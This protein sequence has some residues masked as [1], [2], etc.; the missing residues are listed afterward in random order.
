MRHT[1]RWFPLAA[2]AIAVGCSDSPTQ[3]GGG[4][5]NPALTITPSSCQERSSLDPTFLDYHFMF[6]CGAK[7]WLD[8]TNG[9]LTASQQNDVVGAVSDWNSAL[10]QG[11]TGLPQFF[12]NHQV[13]DTRITITVSTQSATN[14]YE[15]ANNPSG[16]PVTQNINLAASGATNAAPFLNILHVEL[17]HVL[18]FGDQWESKFATAGVSD[19]CVRYSQN[20]PNNSTPCEHEIE[21]LFYT[22]G[23]RPGRSLL[24]HHI[25]TGFGGLPWAL[26]VSPGGGQPVAVHS[27]EF[28]RV[29]PAF[30]AGVLQAPRPRPAGAS[31]PGLPSCPD[32]SSIG[33]TW[34]SDNSSIASVSGS[35]PVA[36]ITGGGTV[37]TTVV[38]AAPVVNGAYDLAFF[39]TGDSI[40]VTNAP[41]APTSIVL[42][43]GAN[44]TAP[45]GTTLPVQPAVRVTGSG[46]AVVPGATVDFAVVSGGGSV[47]PASVVTDGSGQAS[48]SW[49]LGSV[50]GRQIISAT[51]H[52]TGLAVRDTATATGAPA[53]NLAIYAG[54]D[55]T[56]PA[57]TRLPI[58]PTVKVTDANGNGV[59]GVT[60]QFSAAFLNGT[61]SPT[62]AVTS[63]GG[64][65]STA[66]TLGLKATTKTM[67][68][69]STGLSGSPAT[70]TATATVGDGNFVVQSCRVVPAGPKNYNY[71]TLAWTGASSG[72]HTI[73]ESTSSD[74]ATATAIAG[75]SGSSGSVEV[76]GYLQ[77]APAN[78]RYW[79]LDDV[80]PVAG[81]PINTATCLN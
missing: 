35:G 50:T 4:L 77:Q 79:W 29:N 46:G 31:R 1:S 27:L 75:G 81:N 23:L 15:G 36:T 32:S 47:A 10:S 55:Q 5:G 22:Y 66:W 43:A 59:D 24:D 13:G 26:E 65:A 67:T 18:G 63:G 68:A 40:V 33:Y 56:A 11:V 49:H 58:N 17:T 38:R 45:A 37:G 30:C 20:A 25:L 2:L 57:G 8:T 76:G 70:F 61:V 71:F 16:A 54:N 12:L 69:T 51:V 9:G 62:S 41:P 21:D 28:R 60:V 48:T 14:Q 78:Y 34:S 52:G 74:P 3:P 42:T 80:T 7:I 39:F 44:Q 53:A 73:Y 19:H 64:F 72:S 6:G